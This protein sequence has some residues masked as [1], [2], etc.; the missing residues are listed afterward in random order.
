MKSPLAKARD[1]W[2]LSEEGERCCQGSTKG[3]Y[4]KNRLELAFIAGWD[5]HSKLLFGTA[6]SSKRK[7]RKT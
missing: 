7:T 1:K 3:Q 2:L 4:L 6:Q 5:A